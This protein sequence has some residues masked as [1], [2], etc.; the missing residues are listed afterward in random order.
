MSLQSL[1]I[2]L[3]KTLEKK[4]IQMEGTRWWPLHPLPWLRRGQHQHQRLTAA[5]WEEDGN[6]S[7]FQT[8]YKLKILHGHV[9]DEEKIP[10]IP[11][12]ARK[13]SG[14]RATPPRG[15]V[16]MAGSSG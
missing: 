2:S 10:R 13:L 5:G 16:N 7:S 11:V 15:S 14:A 1:G 8:N 12:L 6:S 4:N 9:G 3:W